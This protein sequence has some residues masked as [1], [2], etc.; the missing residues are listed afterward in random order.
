MTERLI[1]VDQPW[2]RD[3]PMPEE[4]RATGRSTSVASNLTG[5]DSAQD[6]G[7]SEIAPGTQLDDHAT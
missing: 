5:V 4:T 3:F 1:A 2:H 6:M 7:P